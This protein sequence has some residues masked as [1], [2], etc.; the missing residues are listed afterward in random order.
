MNKARNRRRD[1]SVVPRFHDLK[2]IHLRDKKSPSMEFICT[3]NETEEL[4]CAQRKMR[5]WEIELFPFQ[6]YSWL[7]IIVISGAAFCV[8]MRKVE[9]HEFA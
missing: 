8:H 9:V 1:K 5:K 2:S 6:D 4:R 7:S 3:A